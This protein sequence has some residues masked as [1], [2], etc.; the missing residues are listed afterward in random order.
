L[1]AGFLIAF[2]GRSGQEA[3]QPDGLHPPVGN[4]A[5]MYP[6]DWFHRQRAYPDPDY[7]A[8]A[9]EQAVADTRAQRNPTTWGPSQSAGVEDETP[10]SPSGPI[11]IGGRIT[12][13]AVH[14]GV[15]DRIF[16]GVATGGVFR[17]DDDG[18]TWTSVFDTVGP[19]SI[20][21]IAIDPQDPDRIY[22][23]SA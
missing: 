10:W 7:P 3:D 22:V 19:F 1:L 20:G 4:R 21:A 12:A 18:A 6:N 17:S 11:N 15:P 23:G 14:P 13:V 16:V 9:V 5:G 8:S 2:F